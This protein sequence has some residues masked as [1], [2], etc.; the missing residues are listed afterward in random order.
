MIVK[1]DLS[2]TVL[3]P[4]YSTSLSSFHNSYQSNFL[5]AGTFWIWTNEGDIAPKGRTITFENLFYVNCNGPI[6]LNI[7]AD[8][9]FTAY[10]DGEIVVQG[11]NYVRVYSVPL[12]VKC[13]GHNLTVTVVKGSSAFGPG[14]IFAVFQDQSGCFNCN[15][16]GEWNDQTCS[17][18]CVTVCGCDDTKIWVA[19]PTCA[20]ICMETIPNLN[21]YLQNIDSQTSNDISI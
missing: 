2:T 3:T 19:Y 13:G 16:N 15:L 9:S 5:G 14:V 18:E 7:T 10:L 20:C 1:S 21:K 8:Q 11:D 12:N 4:G 17:C 6:T